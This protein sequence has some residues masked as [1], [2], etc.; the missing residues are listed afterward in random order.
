[1]ISPFLDGC[2]KSL[3]WRN[4][5][6]IIKWGF[7]GEGDSALHL[8]IF[9]PGTIAIYL[10]TFDPGGISEHLH[11]HNS[12]I[13]PYNDNESG[14]IGPYNDNEYDEIIGPYNGIWKFFGNASYICSAYSV[15]LGWLNGEQTCEQPSRIVGK[16]LLDE[17]R[18]KRFKSNA[19]VS[20]DCKT[21]N[22][23]CFNA[24]NSHQCVSSDVVK[25]MGSRFRA[26]GNEYQ[27]GAV[28][29]N[30]SILTSFKDEL[31]SSFRVNFEDEFQESARLSHL[32]DD[33]S[34]VLLIP[35]SNEVRICTPDD[36]AREVRLC[37][38]PSGTT[39]GDSR[40]VATHTATDQTLDTRNTLRYLG[41]PIKS[42]TPTFW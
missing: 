22:F 10:P 37:T 26:N 31:E 42:P 6:G 20:F 13:G 41:V 33:R 8:P 15:L 40:P 9:D 1:L 38:E 17:P 2:L 24:P 28:T 18:W 7:Y 14:D 4:K 11:E 32:D 27:V 29:D 19:Q 5:T 30:G 25:L 3:H 12:R 39:T 21:V 36:V 23:S 16:N 35:F 34:H